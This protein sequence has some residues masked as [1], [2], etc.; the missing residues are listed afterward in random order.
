MEVR[1]AERAVGGGWIVVEAFPLALALALA[2]GTLLPRVVVVVVVRPSGLEGAPGTVALGL[3]LT[4]LV[5]EITRPEWLPAVA[6]AA[7]CAGGAGAA[8]DRAAGRY[9]KKSEVMRLRS[10]A[11]V[12][13]EGEE[14]VG[15]AAG[16]V[17]CG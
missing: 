12:G 6:G 16:I 14:S 5:G 11:G 15:A 13:A 1:R 17:A 8:G 9:E 4:G 2:A 7:T 10:E 3:G